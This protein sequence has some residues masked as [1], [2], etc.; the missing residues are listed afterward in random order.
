MTERS[1]EREFAQRG[2]T[3]AA[4]AIESEART[5]IFELTA[6]YRA[7][8]IGSCNEHL[9]A[10]LARRGA[11]DAGDRDEHGRLAGPQELIERCDPVVH[12]AIPSIAFNTASG[13]AGACRSGSGRSS[14]AIASRIA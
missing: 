9:C 1:A 8:R 7:D 10:E 5:F 14:V 12:L 13:V 6:A 3:F 11:G 4:E 2:R